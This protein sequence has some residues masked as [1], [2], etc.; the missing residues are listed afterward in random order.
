[1][2]DV[3]RALKT[4]RRAAELGSHPARAFLHRIHVALG[5]GQIPGEDLTIFLEDYARCGSLAAIEGYEAMRPRESERLSQVLGDLY[6]G[7]GA[8]WYDRSEMLHGLTRSDWIRDDFLLLQAEVLPDV[9]E[10]RV[11]T[12]GDTLLHFV[13]ACGRHKP[14]RELIDQHGFDVNCRNNAGDTPLI[15]ACRSGHGSNIRLLLQV[16]NADPSLTAKNGETALHWLVSLNDAT[17]VP[18]ARDL[19]ARGADLEA[20]TRERICHSK[21]PGTVELCIF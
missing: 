7:V 4:L 15:C 10:Y 5:C 12:R 16:Y 21:F 19:I 18:A 11:N 13:S 14:L 8:K 17:I 20:M 1:V 2:V 3:E 9:K 6:G